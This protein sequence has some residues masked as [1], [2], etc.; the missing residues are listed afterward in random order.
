MVFIIVSFW[1]VRRVCL[2]VV[3]YIGVDDVCECVIMLKFMN[4][5]SYRIVM[6]ENF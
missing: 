1:N 3:L 4:Y 2:L 5:V 6:I